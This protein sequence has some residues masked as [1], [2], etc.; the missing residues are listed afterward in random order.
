LN[1]EFAKEL[2]EFKSVDELRTRIREQL[3]SQKR[4]EIEHAAKDKLVEELVSR[5]NFP[6]PE[7]LVDQ[8]IT[9]RLE[10]GFRALAAQGM[11]AEDMRKMDLRRLRAGQR[12]AAVREVKASL[13]LERIADKENIEAS[14]T[15]LDTEVERLAAQSRQPVEAVRK[16]LTDDGT[17]ERMRER[18]RNEK[19]L[20]FLYQRS[21]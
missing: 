12:E 7:S 14:D 6:V 21:A 19:T 1:D 20:D 15:E 4:H 18:I 3:E 5:N 10:R 11:R 13:I 2:G 8:Q 17:L 16:K 9:S